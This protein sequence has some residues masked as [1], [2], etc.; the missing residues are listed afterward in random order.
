MTVTIKVDESLVGEME[1]FIRNRIKK[2][3]Y[4]RVYGKRYRGTCRGE[5]IKEAE[6]DY[7]RKHIL[8][9]TNRVFFRITKRPFPVGG[10]CELCGRTNGKKLDYHHWNDEK[11]EKGLWL[12]YSCHRLG[13]L[14]DKGMERKYLELK[15]K[16]EQEAK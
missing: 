10:A 5:E 14:V 3:E 9:T 8:V 7:G 16:V 6:R 4:D 2:R 1:R 11:P 15:A 13:E 12:C